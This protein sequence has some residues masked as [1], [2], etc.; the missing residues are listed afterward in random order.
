MGAEEPAPA[1]WPTHRGL[2]H[3]QLGDISS[4][5]VTWAHCKCWMDLTDVMK[6]RPF[7][8]CPVTASLGPWS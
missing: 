8:I 4:P 6:S 7:E 3:G 5:K 2:S 1:N